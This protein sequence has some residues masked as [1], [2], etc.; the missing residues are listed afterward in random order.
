[1]DNDTLEILSNK[2]VIDVNQGDCL[3]IYYSPNYLAYCQIDN[4]V[5]YLLNLSA[6]QLG[7]QGKKVKADGDSEVL[8]SCLYI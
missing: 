7:T 1:M 3:T 4:K 8:L 6:D 5:K 2:E